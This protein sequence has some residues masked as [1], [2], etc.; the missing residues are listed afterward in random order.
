MNEEN[1]RTSRCRDSIE[2]DAIDCPTPLIII[3]QVDEDAYIIT[4]NNTIIHMSYHT[5]VHFFVLLT[6]CV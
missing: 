3:D 5:C 4:D 2:S 1:I 6:F